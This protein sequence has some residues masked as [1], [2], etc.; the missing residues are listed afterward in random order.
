MGRPRPPGRVF[1]LYSDYARAW[2]VMEQIGSPVFATT[3]C[4]D[5]LAR[6]AAMRGLSLVTRDVGFGV[7]EIRLKLARPG[8]RAGKEKKP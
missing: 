1:R 4:L 3:A 2:R 8:G 5:L 7:T 6:R